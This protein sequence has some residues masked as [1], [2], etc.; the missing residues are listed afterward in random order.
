[1]TLCSKATLGSLVLLVAVACGR[2]AHDSDGGAGGQAG[3]TGGA[4]GPGGGSADWGGGGSSQA[5]AAGKGGSTT[6]GGASGEG[7]AANTG[8]SIVSDAG[9]GGT[10]S[11]SVSLGEG[12]WDTALVLRVTKNASNAS[13][14]CAAASFTLHVSPS[15]NNLKAIAGRNGAVQRGELIGGTPGSPRYSVSQALSVPTG[16][17]CDSS[18]IAITEERSR[19]ER[20]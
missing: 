14:S 8:G 5:G 19:V 12:S 7:N 15:G 2:T 3:G 4:G 6:A 20:R 11:D 17:G 1:M 10:G 18:S 16:G 9:A 13:F